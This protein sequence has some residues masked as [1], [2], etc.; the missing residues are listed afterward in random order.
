MGTATQRAELFAPLALF[1]HRNFA[2]LWGGELIAV[3]GIFITRIAAALLVY[4]VT[5]SA[6]SVGLT[7]AAS[8][9]PSLLIGLVAGVVV[10]RFDRQRIMVAVNVG[11]GVLV[12]LIPWLVSVN[13]VWLYAVLML[14]GLLSQFFLP[15]QASVLPDVVPDDDRPAAT[16]LFS[17][18]TFTAS[19]LGAV[20][21]GFIAV[22]FPIAWAFYLAGVAYLLGAGLNALLKLPPMETPGHTDV[23]SVTRN[24]RAGLKFT[25]DTPVLR[26]LLLVLL[27]GSALIGF[28]NAVNLPFAT[29]SLGASAADYGLL[30]GIPVIGIIL[31]SYALASLANR[32]FEGQWLSLSLL[33]LGIAVMGYSRVTTVGMAIALYTVLYVIDAAYY[34]SPPLIVQRNTTRE[35][36]G[37]VF[38]TV[39]VVRN[40]GTLLGI[41]AV[42]LA[43]VLDPRPLLLGVAVLFLGL[44]GLSFVLP[45]LGQPGA[46]W[47]QML[48]LLKTAPQA[49][50]LGRGRAATYADLEALALH[51]PVLGQLSPELRQRLMS[52]A[53]VY[54]APPGT[55]VVQQGETSD[56][57][58]FLLAGRTA[59]VKVEDGAPRVLEVHNAGDF[60]G[61][62]AA[63]SGVPRTADVLAEQPT[64]LLQVPSEA[65]RQVARDPAI[66]R[67]LFSKM[68][69]RMARLNL[70][71]VPGRLRL[72]QATLR[73]LR[74]AQPQPDLVAQTTS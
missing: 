10:D 62:I 54:D 61:E 40:L 17:I 65:L 25:L 47:R 28:F 56:A 55:A 48:T 46:E 35:M 21:A 51:L 5:G 44:A 38:S 9:L 26:S 37:R 73:E 6:L 63:L 7:Q 36:R 49:P 70:I 22:Q 23:A 2:L 53:R 71:D 16:S 42:G 8:I 64:Q 1:R 69:E 4:Q 18:S 45:G 3:T 74:T 32:L 60:F 11:V 27:G 34:I 33:G 72:D 58:Y 41:S 57:A 19:A 39:F 67:L 43:D 59:A 15:A 50:R 20:L 31:G 24:V 52:A 68:T 14:N 12:M 29:R 13:L 30:E 66:Q